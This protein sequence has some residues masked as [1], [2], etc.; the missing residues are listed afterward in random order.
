LL[1]SSL[2]R[3]LRDTETKADARNLLTRLRKRQGLYADIR[4]EIDE[5][6]GSQPQAPGDTPGRAD[7]ETARNDADAN[8]DAAKAVIDEMLGETG[9]VSP[10]RT[11]NAGERLTS[12]I[13]GAVIGFAL[14]VAT[15]IF[16]FG[17]GAV[18]V[19]ALAVGGAAT[20]AISMKRPHV[21]RAAI[22]GGILGGIAVAL[23]AN[24]AGEGRS[25]LPM[26]FV[27]GVPPG[28]IVGALAG[29]QIGK[30]RNVG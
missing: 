23:I 27:F 24:L 21:I 6:L 26:S 22:A 16:G 28:L 25:A 19:L 10:P 18:V 7:R 14:G 12:A 29:A 13:V 4:D 11:S 20:G 8:S 30:K 2:R 9:L 3:A 5:L 15:G 17:G 1:V